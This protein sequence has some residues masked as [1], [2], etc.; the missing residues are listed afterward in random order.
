MH[1]LFHFEFEILY[2]DFASYFLILR[3]FFVA[4][5]L[6]LTFKCIQ[7]RVFAALRALKCKPQFSSCFR[8]PKCQT[9]ALLPLF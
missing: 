4:D 5:L 3:P 2:W 9:S 8:D 1:S 7:R 6:F